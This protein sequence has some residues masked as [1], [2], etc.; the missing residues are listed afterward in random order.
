LLS[1]ATRDPIKLETEYLH[2]TGMKAARRIARLAA[3][4]S[5]FLHPEGQIGMKT[6][7]MRKSYP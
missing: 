5:A 6:G 1:S 3:F 7:E 4:L 2:Q